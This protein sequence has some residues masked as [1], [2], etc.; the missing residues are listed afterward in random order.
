MKIENNKEPELEKLEVNVS[1]Y[2]N[3]KESAKYKKYYNS[4]EFCDGLIYHQTDWRIPTWY[5]LFGD[6]LERLKRWKTRVR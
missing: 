3:K 6:M 2:N 4:E 5:M 1:G